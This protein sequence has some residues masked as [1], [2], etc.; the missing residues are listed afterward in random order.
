MEDDVLHAVV[1]HGFAET[2]RGEEVVVVVF[3]RHHDRFAHGLEPGEVDRA[4]D[5]VLFKDAVEHGA[6]AHVVFIEGDLFARDH[7]HT[8]DRLRAGIYKVVD[9]DDLMAAVEQLHAGV[10]ADV[11]GAAG[12]EDVHF[13]DE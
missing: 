4:V 7:F 9:D 10:A 12:D 2:D 8:L 11:A 13:S 3:Q 1:A 5:A 6:V